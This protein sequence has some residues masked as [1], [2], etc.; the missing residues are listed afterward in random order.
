VL[1]SLAEAMRLGSVP[2]Y[3]ALKSQGRPNDPPDC[4]GIDDN[5]ARV[6]IEVTELVDGATIRAVKHGGS[7]LASRKWTQEDF[8]LELAR[9]IGAK[10]RRYPYLKEPPTPADT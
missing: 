8:R 9:R 3:S 2:F 10:D 4:E 7:K 6:A 1:E 5:G